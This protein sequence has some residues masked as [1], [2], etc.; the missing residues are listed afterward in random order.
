MFVHDDSLIFRVLLQRGH[1]RVRE[2]DVG[3]LDDGVKGLRLGLEVVAFDTLVV[4][5][6]LK[7]MLIGAMT[8]SHLLGVVNKGEDALDKSEQGD[9]TDGAQG[10][11]VKVADHGQRLSPREIVLFAIE[12][13]ARVIGKTAGERVVSV[14]VVIVL[15]PVPVES[16]SLGRVAIIGESKDSAECLK[17]GL[18]SDLEQCGAEDPEEEEAEDMPDKHAGDVRPLTIL[19]LLLEGTV[20]DSASPCTTFDR[21]INLGDECPPKEDA[22]YGGLGDIPPMENHCQVVFEDLEKIHV[23]TEGGCCEDNDYPSKD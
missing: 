3:G 5:A 13:V 15:A 23:E 8:S 6:N 19:S 14:I 4:S 12:Q 16:A 2:G 11:L 21:I 22:C 9:Q 1:D 10:R 17:H 18:D 20:L 7:F